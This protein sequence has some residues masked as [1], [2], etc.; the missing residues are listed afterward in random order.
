MAIQSGDILFY[1]STNAGS[2]GNTTSGTLATA[3]GKYCSTSQINNNILNNLF[4]DASGA[5][6]AASVADYRAIYV[7]NV[8][9]SGLTL[10]NAVVYTSGAVAGGADATIA[11]DNIL[12]SG[13]GSSSQQGEVIASPTTAPTANGGFSAPTT[14]GTALSLG[15]I[16]SGSGRMVW[17]KRQCNNTGAV[18]SDGFSIVVN[19]DSAA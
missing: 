17:V 2:A 14:Y 10:Q 15:N 4:P 3:L 12:S 5:Q 6:N 18:N 8:N 11:V 16:A 13:I 1:L 7:V 19:G 9:A